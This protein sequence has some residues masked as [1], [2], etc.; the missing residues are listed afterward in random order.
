MPSPHLQNLLLE[1]MTA[2]HRNG[3]D[4]QVNHLGMP[5]KT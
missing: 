5:R 1:A 3:S 2:A 4:A